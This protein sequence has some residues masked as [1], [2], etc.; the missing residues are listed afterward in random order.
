MMMSEQDDAMTTVAV[1]DGLRAKVAELEAEVTR[2]D[3]GEQMWVERAESAMAE[4][5]ALKARRCETC[6][7]WMPD[8]D[9]TIYGWCET[10]IDEENP[11]ATAPGF[12]CS[13]WAA[14]EEG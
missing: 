3:A 12:C 4:L 11:I 7:N 2:R 6:G 9:T 10:V 13:R 5:A 8:E 1:I 14:R